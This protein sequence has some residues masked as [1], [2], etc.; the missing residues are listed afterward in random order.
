MEI[1]F[2]NLHNFKDL[3]IIDIRDN[4]SFNKK[5]YPLSINIPFVSL[6]INMNKYLSQDKK[7]LLIC[8]YGFKSQKTSLILNKNGFCTYSLKGGIKSICQ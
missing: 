6:I 3:I 7:Y 8:E 5:H 4:E 2:D 1:T